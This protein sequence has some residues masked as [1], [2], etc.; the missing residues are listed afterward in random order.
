MSVDDLLV[1]AR[2]RYTR[3]SASEAWAA[4]GAGALFVDVRPIHQRERDGEVPG[5]VVVGRN[6][7]EWRLDPA[8]DWRMPE[9]AG[10]DQRV[11]LLCNEGCST[12]LAAV[13]LLDLGLVAVTDVIGGFQAWLEAG[14]PTVP[15]GS[16]TDRTAP[17]SVNGA[18]ATP[19]A[20]YP[21]GAP[22]G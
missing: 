6:V 15:A 12:Q 22:G 18:G 10:V 20:R 2:A 8:G 9:A 7:L 17:E 16:G 21:H 13:S 4:L 19:V 11:I 3:L 5:A 14:L 1:A